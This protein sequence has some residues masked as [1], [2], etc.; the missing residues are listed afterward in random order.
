MSREIQIVTDVSTTIHV[1]TCVHKLEGSV[2]QLT[3][4]EAGGVEDSAPFRTI[5]LYGLVMLCFRI[6]SATCHVTRTFTPVISNLRCPRS[7]RNAPTAQAQV[8]RPSVGLDRGGRGGGGCGHTHIWRRFVV[9]S[10]MCMHLIRA[11]KTTWLCS[12]GNHAACCGYLTVDGPS[13]F[14]PG[15]Q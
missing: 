1:F 11:G 9:I 2:L 15:W 14:L 6:S 7:L 3:G 8:Q 5:Q 10:A 4:V 12:C 13:W